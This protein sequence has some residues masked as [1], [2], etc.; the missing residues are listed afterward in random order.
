MGNVDAG[1][2]VVHLVAG[3]ACGM[4]AACVFVSGL[5]VKLGCSVETSPSGR[6]FIYISTTC[7]FQIN[8]DR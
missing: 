5:I 3:L 6:S 2:C 4:C 8:Q 1:S 7:G